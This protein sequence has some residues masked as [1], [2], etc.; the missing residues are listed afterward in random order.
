VILINVKFNFIAA[1]SSRKHLNSQGLFIIPHEI[2]CTEKLY[3]IG[4]A[5]DKAEL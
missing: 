3:N 5:S 2:E 4:T 1:R